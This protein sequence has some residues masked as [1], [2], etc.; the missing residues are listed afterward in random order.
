MAL[1]MYNPSTRTWVN[2]NPIEGSSNAALQLL[3]VNIF[4]EMRIHTNYLEA[5]AKGLPMNDDAQN[6]RVD[7]T[8]DWPVNG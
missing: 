5:I 8:Q 6:L 3:L 7:V 1:A 2:S 4:I